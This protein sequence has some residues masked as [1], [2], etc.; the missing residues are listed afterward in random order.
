M[1]VLILLSS[2]MPINNFISVEV[3][4]RLLSFPSGY[5][6]HVVYIDG[7]IIGFAEKYNLP[8]EEQVSFAYE[9]DKNFTNFNPENDPKCIIYSYFQVVSMLPDGR[10][11]LL[12][13]CHDDSASTGFLSTNRSIYAYDWHTGELERLVAGKLTQASNPKFY[14]W[15]PDMTLGIQETNSGW[16]GTIYWIAPEGMSPMDIQFEARG[17]S[18]NLKDHLEGKEHT[19]LIGSPAWSPDGKTIAFFAST[20]GVR[21]KPLPKFNVSYDLYFMNSVTLKPEQELMNVA[22]AGKIVWSP[23]NDYLLFR[24][25]IGRQLICGLWRYRISD[26]MLSLVKEGE[27]ADYIWIANEKI[28]AIRFTDESYTQSQIWEYLL[29]GE[30]PSDLK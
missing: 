21:E 8:K 10:L 6:N 30:N 1:V 18:L 28:I 23:N 22:D 12:K 7:R 16:Q 2:C 9:G 29:S 14:T 13:E 4:E 24:G 26:K 5:Y 25:C 11:G 17:F 3:K 20:Y 27:F 15:N 19:G